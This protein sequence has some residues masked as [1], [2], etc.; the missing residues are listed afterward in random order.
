[1]SSEPFPT[2]IEPKAF[3]TIMTADGQLGLENFR[4][5]SPQDRQALTRGDSKVD[6]L[7]GDKWVCK[8]PWRL[9]QAISTK[10]ADLDVV[11]ELT[12]QLR[13]PAGLSGIPFGYINE[14]LAD[15]TGLKPFHLLRRR[16]SV[17]EDIALCRAARLL[18]IFEY[19]Q[20]IFNHYWA[21]FNNT[22]PSYDD[23]T[24]VES[25]AATEDKI[26]LVGYDAAVFLGCVAKRLAH[27]I[28][29]EELPEKETMSEYLQQHPKLMDAVAAALATMSLKGNKAGKQEITHN[30]QF[31][32]GPSNFGLQYTSLGT[33]AHQAGLDRSAGV[34]GQ[35]NDTPPAP[36]SKGAPLISQAPNLGMNTLYSHNESPTP[37]AYPST[38]SNGSGG[39][40]SPLQRVR[41]MYSPIVDRSRT[42]SPARL[43][44]TARAFNYSDKQMFNDSG[45]NIGPGHVSSVTMDSVLLHNSQTAQPRQNNTPWAN[46]TA[47]LLSPWRRQVSS[48]QQ[49]HAQKSQTQHQPQEHK[50][51]TNGS[52]DEQKQGLSFVEAAKKLFP[53]PANSQHPYVWAV[54]HVLALR[55]QNA[56]YREE[57]YEASRTPYFQF[58]NP[59]WAYDVPTFVQKELQRRVQ[60]SGHRSNQLSR[61]SGRSHGDDRNGSSEHTA[62]IGVIGDRAT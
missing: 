29:K 31:S 59:A 25:L 28:Y 44:P 16:D 41:E 22:T 47:A 62:K 42:Q 36:W 56:L 38:T 8:M 24:A 5:L 4:N 52:D 50:G 21:V 13:L 3:D 45:S 1:M 34:Y 43:D 30:N 54:Q 39:L 17:T 27:V 26:G 58:S 11:D 60:A 6:I 12:R 51:S 40:L 18:G 9:F 49:V 14:W 2:Y 33:K 35:A 20:H 10:T 61:D 46:Q 57:R 55:E 53:A 48:D 7:I 37:M 19:A 32:S 23:L 15:V